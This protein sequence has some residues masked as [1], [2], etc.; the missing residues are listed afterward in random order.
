MKFIWSTD[1][2]HNLYLL[3]ASTRHMIF[4]LRKRELSQYN[5][6]PVES[7][8]LSLI[9]SLERNQ[10]T[11]ANLSRMLSREPHTISM[12]LNRMEKKGLIVKKKDLEKKNLVRIELTAEGSDLCQKA[13]NS[14]VVKEIFSLLNSAQRESFESLIE[15]LWKAAKE[16][17][18]DKI[19]S[20]LIAK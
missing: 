14:K 1:E 18:G 16:K 10:A 9:N 13:I 17:L 19:D 20:E 4:K 15:I 6:S 5:L 3:L 11:P 2:E 8:V 12:L 7:G